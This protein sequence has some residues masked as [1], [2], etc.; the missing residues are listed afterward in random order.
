MFADRDHPQEPG[1]DAGGSTSQEPIPVQLLDPGA[2]EDRREFRRRPG[3]SF[4]ISSTNGPN[5][6][7]GPNGRDGYFPGSSGLCAKKKIRTW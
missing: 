7:N 1:P 6:P 3:M 4:Y 5:G 2:P